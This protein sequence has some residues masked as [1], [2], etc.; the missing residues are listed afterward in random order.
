MEEIQTQARLVDLSASSFAAGGL[1][2]IIPRAE[3]ADAIE[4]GEYPA[5]LVLDI[6]RVEVKRGDEERGDEVAHARVAVNWDEAALE[7]LLQSTR[8]EEVVLWFDPSQLEQAFEGSEVDAHGLRERAA[9]F[10]VTVAAAGAA[11]GAGLAG[12]GTTVLSDSGGGGASSTPVT[13][14]S[15]VAGGGTGQA[16]AAPASALPSFTSDVASGGTGQADSDALARYQA[17]VGVGASSEGLSFVSDVASGGTGQ[18]DGDALARFEANVEGVESTPAT[19]GFVSD[20]ANSDAVSRY[21]ATLS[22]GQSDAVTRYQANV[23]DEATVASSGGG[24]SSPSP[25]EAAAIAAGFAL[26]IS[27]AGFTASRSRTRPR[28]V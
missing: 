11:A 24:I 21:E 5:R 22:S 12:P 19:A 26:F 4:Q 25:G 23:G 27:A 15:D 3:I 1:S 13:F 16:A 9:V 7:Q 14:V 17:N 28:P 6:E 10:A 20:V 18:A 2:T 8:D